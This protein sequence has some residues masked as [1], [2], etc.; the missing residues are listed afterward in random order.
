M[1]VMAK[2]T[3]MLEPQYIEPAP[4]LGPGVPGR[5]GSVMGIQV[6]NKISPPFIIGPHASEQVPFIF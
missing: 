3:G 2:H 6:E 1:G 5:G 4:R